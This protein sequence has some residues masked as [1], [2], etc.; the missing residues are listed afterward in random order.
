MGASDALETAKDGSCTLFV[1]NDG[2]VLVDLLG[3]HALLL[4]S[5][6]GYGASACFPDN[7]TIIA[8]S[9]AHTFGNHGDEGKPSLPALG[10]RVE[11]VA[12]LGLVGDGGRGAVGGRRGEGAYLKPAG[13]SEVEGSRAART[14]TRQLDVRRSTP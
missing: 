7:L 11:M 2:Q 6:G 8:P 14:P 4:T 3:H 12:F 10:L 5:D 9:T 13:D 1:D